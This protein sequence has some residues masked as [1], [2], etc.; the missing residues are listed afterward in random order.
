[1]AFICTILYLYWFV[2]LARILFSWV[3][4]EPGTAVGSVY[5]VVYSLTEPVLGPIRR[6]IPPMRIGLAAIDVGPIIVLLVVIIL[7]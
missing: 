7:C 1:M 2:I 4:V 6:V 5:S 3:R